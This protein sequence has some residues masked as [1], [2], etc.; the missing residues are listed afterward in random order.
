MDIKVLIN[1]IKRSLTG[2]RKTDINYLK[3]KL[4]EYQNSDILELTEFLKKELNNLKNIETEI[5]ENLEY[6]NNLVT[7]AEKNIF[8]INDFNGA[9]ESLETFF[10]KQKI[11]ISISFLLK[12][13]LNILI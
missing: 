1:N 6:L 11:I 13:T 7:E 12:G 3:L 9:R 8:D 10:I 4:D 2:D 5:K